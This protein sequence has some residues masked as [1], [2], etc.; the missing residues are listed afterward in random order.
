MQNK[1]HWFNF[2]SSYQKHLG[3]KTS[4]R[5]RTSSV[6]FICY[7]GLDA[8]DAYVDV[9]VSHCNI[10]FPRNMN[11]QEG[12]NLPR[13]FRP[14]ASPAR[15]RV[16]SIDLSFESIQIIFPYSVSS[17]PPFRQL[18]RDTRTF[19]QLINYFRTNWSADSDPEW[20]RE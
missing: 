6:S 3:E 10:A 18:P 15:A 5:R 2:S 4:S 8:I 16:Y 12:L 1:G 13:T 20:I 9:D 19:G 11:L 7:D 14:R 17:F